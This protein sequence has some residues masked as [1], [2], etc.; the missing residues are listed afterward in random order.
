MTAMKPDPVL[1]F[2][3]RLL[4]LPRRGKQGVVIL[5]DILA[6]WV[7]LWL[8]FTLRLE[9]WHWPSVQ[10][11][12]VYAVSPLLFLPVFVRFGLYRAIFRYTG[13]ATMQTLLKAAVVYGLLF[14]GV[15]LVTFPV[16]R[17]SVRRRA[18]ANLV[19]RCW[20][21]TRG[22]GPAS[23]SIVALER[24]LRQRLLIYGAGSAGA[25]T[26]AAVANAGE[27]ELLGFVDDDVTR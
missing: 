7:A 22:H 17:A 27:F 19:S 5:V 11:L 4:G 25:Q 15:V 6:S 20:S 23:G 10:Q 9:V 2:T 12:W 14:L 1:R 26:A 3:S 8:A 13:L 24:E 21:A 18:A 16:R